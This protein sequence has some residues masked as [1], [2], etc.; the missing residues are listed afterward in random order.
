[1]KP[2]SIY[3]TLEDAI[4]INEQIE[5]ILRD[6]KDELNNKILEINAENHSIKRKITCDINDKFQEMIWDFMRE[7]IKMAETQTA[8][9]MMA[10]IENRR[11]EEKAD[12]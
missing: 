7:R 6:L 1:M 4:R 2:E 10:E 9:Y 12:H 11:K 3:L 8:C 5:N